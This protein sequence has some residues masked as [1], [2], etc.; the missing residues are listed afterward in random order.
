MDGIAWIVLGLEARGYIGEAAV[1]L[2]AACDPHAS[3][4]YR[5]RIEDRGEVWELDWRP[6]LQ[7]LLKD[8]HHGE[9][10]GVIA[11]R[12]H[13]GII[14][15]ILDLRARCPALPWVFSGGVFQN[16]RICELLAER[17]PSSGPPLGLPGVIPPNDGGLA[18]GQLAILSAQW[19]KSHMRPSSTARR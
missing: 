2:D 5:W 1:Q 15:F 11:E 8:I 9:A 10:P 17:W 19:T 7:E 12:F 6:M 14:D 18:V 3:G 16:C 4:A 13:R